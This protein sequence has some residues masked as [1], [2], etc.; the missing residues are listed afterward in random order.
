MTLTAACTS[1]SLI[2]I[3]TIIAR[4]PLLACQRARSGFPLPAPGRVGSVQLRALAVI[5]RFFGLS[6]PREQND[7]GR[8]LSFIVRGDPDLSDLE[9]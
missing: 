4:T 7:T 2:V 3:E 1:S 5:E 6:L 8:L 9:D